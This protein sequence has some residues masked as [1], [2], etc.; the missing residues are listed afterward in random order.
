LRRCRTVARSYAPACTSGRGLYAFLRGDILS[1]APPA[2]LT[3][4]NAPREKTRAASAFHPLPQRCCVAHRA[5]TVSSGRA[6]RVS[7]S[8]LARRR[9]V[10][11]LPPARTLLPL[12][13]AGC[14]TRNTAASPPSGRFSL[15]TDIGRDRGKRNA[16][17]RFALGG[18]AGGLRRLRHSIT[19]RRHHAQDSA[20]AYNQHLA[21][22]RRAGTGAYDLIGWWGGGGGCATAPHYLRQADI[23]TKKE[24]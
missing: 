15:K 12:L 10:A 23:I 7:C 22:Q 2:H 18:D 5:R 3:R 19:R 14:I 1:R 13:R 17:C 6:L 20:G 11:T 9:A 21:E 24:K 4:P 8:L 16:V